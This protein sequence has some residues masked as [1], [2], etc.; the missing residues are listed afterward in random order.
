MDCKATVQLLQE[1]TA[2]KSCFATVRGL[3]GC[4]DDNERVDMQINQLPLAF[5]ASQPPKQHQLPASQ[6]K[7]YVLLMVNI[8]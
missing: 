8:I 2:E 1:L 6:I 7:A 5:Q 3:N 4:C